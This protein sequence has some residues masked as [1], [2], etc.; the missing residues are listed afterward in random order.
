MERIIK[1]LT[2]RN[3]KNEYDFKNYCESQWMVT[4]NYE[5]LHVKIEDEAH[6][7]CKRINFYGR[8][9]EYEYLH[10]RINCEEQCFGVHSIFYDQKLRVFDKIGKDNER[11]DKEGER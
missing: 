6:K 8:Y 5:C 7:K 2:N 11:R 9:Y 4:D 1:W 10:N 3:V